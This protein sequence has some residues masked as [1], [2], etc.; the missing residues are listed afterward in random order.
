M[1]DYFDWFEM[2]DTEWV[3]F[4]KMK[5]VRPARKFWHTITTHLERTNQPPITHWAIMK[6]RL[7]EKYF[8]LLIDPTLLTS[9]WTLGNPL[10]AWLS[11]ST[12]LKS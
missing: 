8:L 9:C 7:K 10:L 2:S 12:V 4:A 3:R 5:P 1:E 6:E 11:T